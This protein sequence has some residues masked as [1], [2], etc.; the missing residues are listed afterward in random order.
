MK[1]KRWKNQQTNFWNIMFK[2]I[3]VFKS[4]YM[5]KVI[6]LDQ[7]FYA[8]LCYHY[9]GSSYKKKFNKYIIHFIVSIGISKDTYMIA[10]SSKQS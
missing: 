8:S 4:K 6:S 10:L 1:N 2:S 9:L 7:K 3:E 5:I